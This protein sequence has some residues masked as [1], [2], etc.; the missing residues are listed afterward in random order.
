MVLAGLAAQGTTKVS[1]LK[2]LDRG[3]DD[4]ESKLNRV[5]AQI[6]RNSR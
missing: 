6:D 1:G 5:G 4:I 3:Y 2:H